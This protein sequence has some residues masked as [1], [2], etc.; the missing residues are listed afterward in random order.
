[1]E[2]QREVTTRIVSEQI[3]VFAFNQMYFV[4][5]QTAVTACFSSK[6]LLLFAFARHCLG[7]IKRQT[8]EVVHVEPTLAESMLI[9]SYSTMG[10][11]HPCI[12][13]WIF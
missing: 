2:K 3:L 12:L 13:I 6:Q 8:T 11:C 9:L 1:M 4:R 7:L 5:R 10:T